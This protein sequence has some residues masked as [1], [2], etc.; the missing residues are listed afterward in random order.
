MMPPKMQNGPGGVA[1]PTRARNSQKAAEDSPTIARHIGKRHVPG[2][3][4]VVVSATLYQ[5]ATG[6]VMALIVPDDIC[7]N[8]SDWHNH[9]AKW[10]VPALVEKKARC[11]AKYEIALH[12]PSIKRNRRAA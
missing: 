1:A 6:L 3:L 4:P 10:P 12:P 7:P 8:C 11:G 5:P 2:Q 9:K